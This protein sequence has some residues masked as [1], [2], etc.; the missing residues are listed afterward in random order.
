MKPTNV[1]LVNLTH[2]Y[3]FTC[4][5]LNFNSMQIELDKVNNNY[6][7]RV[8]GSFRAC[9]LCW[10]EW[11]GNGRWQEERR[12]RLLFVVDKKRPKQRSAVPRESLELRR[13]LFEN[14][15]VLSLSKEIKTT[16]TRWTSMQPLNVQSNEN[17]HAPT[18]ITDFFHSLNVQ[19]T[20][21]SLC[22]WDT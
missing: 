10:R 22:A 8:L 2:A 20:F 3:R 19:H 16:K 5:Y 11:V 17:I 4:I 14:F 21:F 6:C 1:G 12:G 13:I 18:E 9:R 7:D 15:V